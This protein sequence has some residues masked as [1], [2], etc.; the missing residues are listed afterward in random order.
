MIWTTTDDVFVEYTE[1]TSSYGDP[2][3]Q[4]PPRLCEAQTH[5]TF[6]LC[7]TWDPNLKQ[8]LSALNPEWACQCIH[9]IYLCYI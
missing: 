6:P 4:F 7:V 3:E 9:T 8:I 1:T 2:R 5:L